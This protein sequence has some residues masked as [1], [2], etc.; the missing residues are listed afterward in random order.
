M[1]IN[2]ISRHQEFPDFSSPN[3]P[4]I[5]YYHFFRIDIDWAFLMDDDE[6]SLAKVFTYN[7]PI[8]EPSK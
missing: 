1:F 6:F 5:P 2:A 4:P 8:L 3:I 7:F